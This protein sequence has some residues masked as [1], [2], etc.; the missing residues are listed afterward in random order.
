M[1]AIIDTISVIRYSNTFHTVG[2]YRRC[3][4]VPKNV[5]V[6]EFHYY[7][8]SESP[9]EINLDK[10]NIPCTGLQKCEMFGGFEKQNYHF[11]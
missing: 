7:N 10:T 11:V 6:I 8:Y 4:K 1:N 2:V 5:K 3:L 9:W